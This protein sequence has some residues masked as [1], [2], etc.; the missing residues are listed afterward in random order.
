M[1]T[2]LLLAFLL[3]A[4]LLLAP[5]PVM[6]EEA[7]DAV[8]VVA[9]PAAPPPP[10]AARKWEMDKVESSIRFK[11]TQMGKG[12][13]GKIL[14]FTPQIYFDPDKLAESK[15]SVDIDL[16][17][18]DAGDSERNKSL[19]SPDWLDVIEFPSAHFETLGFKKTG[20]KAYVADATLTIRGAIQEIEL[21]FTLDITEDG[22][23][24]KAVM[25][26]SVTLDRS[27]FQL[28]QGDWADPSVIA[29]EIPVEVKVTAFSP[30]NP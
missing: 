3:L 14:Q 2:L 26:G 5:L 9:A 11:G 13:D 18:I 16:R 4:F 24:L 25:T 8:P 20:D 19:L 17:T 12:F 29:N 27:K 30:K 10:P 23:K 28:G 1:R 22:K 21:P 15:V 7:K 6:A